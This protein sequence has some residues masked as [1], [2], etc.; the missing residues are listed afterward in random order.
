MKNQERGWKR[1]CWAALLVALTAASGVGADSHENWIEIKSPHFTAYSNAGESNGKR[2]AEQFEQIRALFEQSFPKLRVDSGD[3]PTILYALRDEDSLKLLIPTYGQNK[4]AAK[5]AGL[6]MPSGDRNFAIVRTDVTGTARNQFHV[7]YHEYAHQLFR[8]NFRG[9]PV[10]LD[11]GLAE[12][13]GGSEIGNKEAR[14]GIA[15]AGQIQLLQKGP[16]LPI[17]TLVS[18]DRTSPLYNTQTH[19]GIFYAESWA[20]VHYLA[21]SPEVRDQDLL[22]KFLRTLQETDDPIEAAS[23]SFGDLKKLGGKIDSYSRQLSF[24]QKQIPL[25]I[26][27]SEKDFS[28]RRLSPA[29]GMIH[30]ADYLLHSNHLPEAIELLHRARDLDPK[31]LGLHDALGYYHYL[32]NDA[33][34]AGKEFD[35]ALE[36]DPND[37]SVYYY[38]AH[39]LLRKSGYTAE[40][41]PLI[42]SNLEKVVA[43]RPDFTPARAFLCIAYTQSPETAAKAVQEA[44]RATNLEPGNF[45]YFIDVGRALLADGKYDDARRVSER[46]QKLAT[47]PRE[48]SAADALT[49]QLNEKTNPAA[50]SSASAPAAR[51]E[52]EE[53]AESPEKS[54]RDAEGQITELICGHPPAVMFTLATSDESILLRVKDI[55]KIE[56]REAPGSAAGSSGD[57]G[58][59]KDRKA[60]ISYTPA[61]DGSAAGDVKSITFE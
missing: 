16:L 47:W 24:Y 18:I 10:W 60:R 21:L 7:M 6:Y 27:I 38:R 11:E 48:R 19:S 45:F 59:W 25:N 61:P 42:R 34:N 17:E 26:S 9:L 32:K 23:K 3:K 8:L 20:L 35:L 50:Q 40:S 13:W 39:I 52:A 56:I 30:Q 2:V 31:A 46:A 53:P 41:T 29:E 55:A 58:K 57:C 54:L 22:N 44:L 4:N 49:R 12:Y 15:D 37:A 28:A 51:P 5:I 43:L 36:A 33:E 1:W 14:V